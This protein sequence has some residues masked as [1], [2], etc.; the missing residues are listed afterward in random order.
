MYK[1]RDILTLVVYE[2]QQA[3][4]CFELKKS[5]IRMILGLIPILTFLFFTIALFMVNYIKNIS[6]AFNDFKPKIIAEYENE[7]KD[8]I[9]EVEELKELTVELNQKLQKTDKAETTIPFLIPTIGQKDL[10]EKKIIRIENPKLENTQFHAILSFDILNGL[11]NT[12]RLTG[13]I[14]VAMKYGA[15]LSIFPAPYQLDHSTN[16]SLLLQFNQGEPFSIAKFRNVKA[17]FALPKNANSSVFFE[18][19]TLSRSGDL[20]VYKTL[21]PYKIKGQEQNGK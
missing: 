8:L 10:T 2:D 14:F 5:Q 19:V 11:E 20:L 21:G 7:K 12:G 13:Y 9:K 18:V 3:A 6:Q 15:N 17:E 1:P 16:N 4:R